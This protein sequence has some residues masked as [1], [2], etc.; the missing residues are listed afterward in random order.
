MEIVTIVLIII[1]VNMIITT[2]IFDYFVNLII[3]NFK[4]Q[5]E[6]NNETVKYISDIYDIIADNNLTRPEKKESK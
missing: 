5:D 1:T 4:I 6:F 2:L 3:D